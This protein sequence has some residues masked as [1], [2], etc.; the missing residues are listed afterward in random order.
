MELVWK[1]CTQ[2]TAAMVDCGASSPFLSKRFVKQHHVLIKPLSSLIT[3]YKIDMTKNKAGTITH[4]AELDVRVGA[5]REKLRFLV[6]D[7]GLED[8][9]LGITWLRDHNPEIDWTAEKLSLTRCACPGSLQDASPPEVPIK[10][11]LSDPAGLELIASNQMTRRAWLKA[12]ILEHATNVLYTAAGYTYSQKV[13]E[14]AGHI[15]HKRLFE[16]IVP[17]HYWHFSKVF[18]NAKSERLPKHQPWDHTI[19]LKEGAPE[20]VRAKVYP[21]PPNEQQELDVFLKDNLRN[22]YITPSKSPRASP[23][24]FIKK[25]DGK[26][27]LVQDYHKLNNITIKN[28]YPLLL[29]ADIINRLSGIKYFSKFDVQWGYCDAYSVRRVW[30]GRRRCENKRR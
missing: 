30:S 8:V 18:S 7:I 29:P 6:T 20:T 3:L 11:N 16:E 24:F 17:A 26:L 9:V 28:Q 19:N 15:K 21:M 25:K 1:N 4:S 13:A 23:V 14:D 22:R 12:G 2:K 10:S 5:H 27:Q